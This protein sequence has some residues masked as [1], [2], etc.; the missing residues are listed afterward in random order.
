MIFVTVLA[1]CLF[2]FTASADAAGLAVRGV[3]GHMTIAAPDDIDATI[4]LGFLLDMDIV[5]SQFGIESYASYWS[6]SESAFGVEASVSDFAMGGR[7]KYKFLT[8]STSVHPYVGAGLGLHFV[9]AGV[10]IPAYDFGGIIIPGTSVEDT[11]VNLGLDLGGGM[12][13][14]VGDRVSLL[15]DAWG[16]V[17]SDVSQFMLR[18]GMIYRIP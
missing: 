6:Q 9:T 8:S 3:G 14:D 16:V 15:T 5:G 11:N 10:E 7:G 4:G 17:V 18:F 12:A 13:F 2:A 1:A